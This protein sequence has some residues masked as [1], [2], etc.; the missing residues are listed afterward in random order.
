MDTYESR[1]GRRRF[2]RSAFYIGAGLLGGAL[3][4]RFFRGAPDY[5]APQEVVNST[6]SSENLFCQTNLTVALT[7]KEQLNASLENYRHTTERLLA[8]LENQTEIIKA[9]DSDAAKYLAELGELKADFARLHE[10]LNSTA[11]ALGACEGARGGLEE[12]LRR[13]K[14]AFDGG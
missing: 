11:E 3:L 10:R 1:I 2:I 5:S 14:E 4:T 9:K 7:Q 12:R 6:A 13:V 8:Q